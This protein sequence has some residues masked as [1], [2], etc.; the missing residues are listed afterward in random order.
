MVKFEDRSEKDEE[1]T[2]PFGLTLSSPAA[3]V[4]GGKPGKG[5]LP[6]LLC[7]QYAASK[8]IDQVNPIVRLGTP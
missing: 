7:W 2:D 1:E 6:D 8:S 5:T 3:T 4:R